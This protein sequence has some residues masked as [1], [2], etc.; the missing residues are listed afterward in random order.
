MRNNSTHEVKEAVPEY[1]RYTYTDYCAWSDDKRWELID[2]VPYAMS[3][4]SLAH[5]EI[6]SQLILA[7]AK[8]FRF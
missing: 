5:Q 4:S 2:G 7:N 1:K 3:A 8:I 6:S